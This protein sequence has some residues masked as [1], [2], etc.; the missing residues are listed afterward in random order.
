MLH[1]LQTLYSAQDLYDLLEVIAIDAHN[2]RIMSELN[3]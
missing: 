3:N 2:K 1:D